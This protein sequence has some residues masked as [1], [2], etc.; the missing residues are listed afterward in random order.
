M[1]NDAQLES[2]AHKWR[3][4]Q[5]EK[6]LKLFKQSQGRDARDSDDL[7]V[8]L[9]TPEGEALLARHHD[10]NGKIIPDWD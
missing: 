5:A 3:L 7:T 4:K 10:E 8:W 2:D 1:T 9:Q 6:I